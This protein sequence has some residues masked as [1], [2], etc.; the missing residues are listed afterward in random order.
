MQ[1]EDVKQLFEI[2]DA[3]DP[4]RRT[5]IDI[6]STVLDPKA[7]L[8]CAAHADQ[9]EDIQIKDLR[10]GS[11]HEGRALRCTLISDMAK[12]TAVMGIVEDSC[13]DA[14]FAAFYDLIQEADVCSGHS[15]A[16]GHQR[17]TLRVGAPSSVGTLRT[18]QRLFPRGTTFVI[19]EP[20]FKLMK[21][22][23]FGIRAHKG[24][25][26]WLSPF[27]NG[28]RVTIV[29]L[30]AKCELNGSTGCVIEA[31]PNEKGRWAVQLD[32]TPGA[33]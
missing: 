8:P 18:C 9:L 28:D 33:S 15:F 32:P 5:N 22:G 17:T 13:G 16:A 31:R 20:Y 23:E 3:T 14:V 29:R 10:V 7:N 30:Q 1:E 2:A 19:K 25:T 21:N 4:G 24:N 6:L 26:E 27:A 11:V 12:Q